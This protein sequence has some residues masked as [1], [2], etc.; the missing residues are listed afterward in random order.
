MNKRD[1]KESN[2]TRE[3]AYKAIPANLIP[4][5][6]FVGQ[7]AEGLVYEGEHG[8]LVIRVIAKSA[9]FD[10]EGEIGEFEAKKVEKE[11]KAM[12]AKIKA[13]KA[14]KEKGE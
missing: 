12:A 14:K 1:V 10:A 3:M 11:N 7:T 4:G 5:H 8:C 9:E 2:A 6:T 13:S